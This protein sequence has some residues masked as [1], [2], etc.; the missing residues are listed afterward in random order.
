MIANYEKITDEIYPWEHWRSLRKK[1]EANSSIRYQLSF[2]K[3]PTIELYRELSERW[4]VS[5]DYI[6]SIH[7]RL[8]YFEEFKT[9]DRPAS[10]PDDPVSGLFKDDIRV[11]NVLFNAGIMNIRELCEC[12]SH[13]ILQLK[14]S[15]E[16]TLEAIET[17]LEAIELHLTNIY[18][19]GTRRLV[20]S[21]RYPIKMNCANFSLNLSLICQSLTLTGTLILTHNDGSMLHVEPYG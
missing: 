5:M 14:N 4:N 13:F 18:G 6:D 3:I 9:Q 19:E 17:A 16:K 15:G 10:H 1:F 21:H 2:D 7:K 8:K 20:N 11:Q 12:D